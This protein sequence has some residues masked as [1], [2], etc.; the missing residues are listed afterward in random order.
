MD[1]D[2]TG[3]SRMPDQRLRDRII[4]RYS[5]KLYL[6]DNN[7][8]KKQVKSESVSTTTFTESADDQES[9]DA[10]SVNHGA[11]KCKFLFFFFFGARAS[12]EPYLAV[13]FKQLGLTPSDIGALY[14]VRPLL[15][16]LFS[17]IFGW[18]ADR[19]NA[20]RVIIYPSLLS[21]SI[22]V[23]AMAFIPQP[24]HI[25][26]TEARNT[27]EGLFGQ[28]ALNVCLHESTLDNFN[29]YSHGNYYP[30]KKNI[31]NDSIEHSLSKRD[32]MRY[33]HMSNSNIT[34]VNLADNNIDLNITSL[35]GTVY[36]EY[37]TTP[38][39]R[40]QAQPYLE[41]PDS[42]LCT[43][44]T[45][46]LY[47]TSDL[48]R[49]FLIAMGLNIVGEVFQA[50]APAIMNTAILN[51]LGE[52]NHHQ[53]GYQRAF[54]SASA[55]FM[56]IVSGLLLD[57]HRQ[58]YN[59]CGMQLTHT[60]YM[61]I[62]IFY[63]FLMTMTVPVMCF[64]DIQ[65][66]EEKKKS[67]YDIKVVYRGLCN[68]RYGLVLFICMWT[69]LCNGL[70][71]AFSF[72]YIEA[73]GGSSSLASLTNLAATFASTAGLLIMPRI[74]ASCGYIKP[75]FIGLLFQ[76]L[77]Y[78]GYAVMQNPWWAILPNIIKGFSAAITYQ[79][80]AAFM[81]E[82]VPPEYLCSLQSV[83]WALYYG[84]GSGVG[85]IL[86]GMCFEYT[87]PVATFWAISIT[88]FIFAFLFI[89]I[90]WMCARIEE[91]DEQCEP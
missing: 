74:N 37:G 54:G 75:I 2:E 8:G 38:G 59:M 80:L 36:Q 63:L 58:P 82:S 70:V 71:K 53:F 52:E 42:V 24:H 41:E 86:G 7:K 47:S 18:V 69:G 55:A 83:M 3:G 29:I 44:S 12:L 65:S 15:S 31:D 90:H 1:I 23:F 73:L 14:S 27:F 51:T 19:Y 26:C 46:W 89:F 9:Q 87:G 72:W 10:C 48:N 81:A 5:E 67:S 77:N 28:S 33:N 78:F 64:F 17:P 43:S 88:S 34:L 25:P 30:M 35:N 21:W 56:N 57:L 6:L 22:F 68:V 20:S 49:I 50:P 85:G 45:T 16:L 40:P 84:F 32:Y 13:Y 66:N 60:N 39:T 11:I 62:F 79:T 91:K 4:Q 76:G 61:P